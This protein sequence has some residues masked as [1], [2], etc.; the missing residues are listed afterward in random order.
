LLACLLVDFSS[1]DEWEVLDGEW[2]WIEWI[3]ILAWVVVIWT[4][5]SY[6]ACQDHGLPLLYVWSCAFHLVP[7][8]R[9]I[10]TRYFLVWKLWVHFEA[11]SCNIVASFEWVLLL[12]GSSSL[13][14]DGD[15]LLSL[16][17]ENI[18]LDC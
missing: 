17:F 15:Y 3:M 2:R 18:F 8:L 7:R 9:G 11:T 12:G 5:L 6:T 13:I 4:F 10:F 1:C 16:I 14:L